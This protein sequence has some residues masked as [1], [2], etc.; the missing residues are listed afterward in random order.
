M[1]K[2]KIGAK[3]KT[4]QKSHA[5]KILERFNF[6]GSRTITMIMLK[7]NDKLKSVNETNEL[8]T[9]SYRQAV[10]ICIKCTE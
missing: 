6:T 2:E 10:G 3:K 1:T 9:F 7:Y 4:S 8:H 5:D